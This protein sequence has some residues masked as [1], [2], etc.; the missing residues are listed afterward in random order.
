[1]KYYEALSLRTASLQG[2]QIANN[3]LASPCVPGYAVATW[4]LV[5]LLLV[6]GL[7][8][9]AGLLHHRSD[10]TGGSHWQTISRGIKIFGQEDIVCFHLR[11]RQRREDQAMEGRSDLAVVRLG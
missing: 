8:A 5:G 11:Q 9:G 2:C 3:L 10:I 6:L 4:G 7:L 1:M